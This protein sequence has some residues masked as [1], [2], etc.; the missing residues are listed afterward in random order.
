MSHRDRRRGRQGAR[1]LHVRGYDVQGTGDRELRTVFE[2]FGAV[3]DVYMP[4]DFF[5]K[6][7]RGFAYVQF[8]VESEAD[9]ARRKLDRTDIF[10]D[11]REIHIM[12]AA[13]ERKTPLDMRRLDILRDNPHARARNAGMPSWRGRSRSPPRGGGKRFRSPSPRRYGGDYRDRERSPYR[14]RRR[15][16]SPFRDR[17][18]RPYHRRSPPRGRSRSPR[19]DRSPY[20]RRDRSRSPRRGRTPPPRRDSPGRG[21]RSPPP[22]KRASSRSPRRDRTPESWRRS[23]PP[24]HRRDEGNGMGPPGEHSRMNGRDGHGE[25]GS[26]HERDGH[27]NSGPKMRSEPISPN[28][29]ASNDDAH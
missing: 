12:W 23:P 22:K 5:T 25:K 14:R 1:S 21:S 3:V 7:L 28:R 24:Y 4:K 16:R 17:P 19:R 29:Q 10:G 6:K 18:Y 15:S 13:G 11:G 27:M 8:A 2:A 9:E 26:D 20:R